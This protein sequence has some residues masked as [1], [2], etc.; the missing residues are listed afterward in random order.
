MV[1]SGSSRPA[2]CGVRAALS[3][4]LLAEAVEE[5]EEH[6]DDDTTTT[7]RRAQRATVRPEDPSSSPENVSLIAP[8]RCSARTPSNPACAARGAWPDQRSGYGSATLS[9][10]LWVS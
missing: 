6:D 5:R 9:P 8:R 4:G 2:A 3:A 10:P 1:P 7:A